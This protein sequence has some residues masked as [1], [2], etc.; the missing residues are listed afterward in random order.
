[1]RRLGDGDHEEGGWCS[2]FSRSGCDDWMTAGKENP[3]GMHVLYVSQIHGPESRRF[4]P[5]AIETARSRMWVS[6]D[7]E[8]ER[9]AAG[10]ILP[11]QM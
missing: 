4:S 2:S 5:S 8:K 11:R 9:I 10:Q 3:R 1:M 7:P 6:V